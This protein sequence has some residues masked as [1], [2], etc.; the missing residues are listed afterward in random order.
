M[1]EA[2][3]GKKRSESLWP[4]WGVLNAVFNLYRCAY[5]SRPKSSISR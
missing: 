2:C 3:P 5:Q 1:G 4:K